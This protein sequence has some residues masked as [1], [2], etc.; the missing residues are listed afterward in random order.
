MYTNTSLGRISLATALCWDIQFR[1]ERLG[2]WKAIDKFTLHIQSR[3]FISIILVSQQ[4]INFNTPRFAAAAAFLD[5]RFDSIELSTSSSLVAPSDGK[6]RSLRGEELVTIHA[7]TLIFCRSEL[8]FPPRSYNP[9][10]ISGTTAQSDALVNAV[11][12]QLLTLRRIQCS[13]ECALRQI[14]PISVIIRL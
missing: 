13:N 4:S 12:S 1:L 5:R 3:Y 11:E 7:P 8:S 9:I 10:G 2:Q 14:M 6:F